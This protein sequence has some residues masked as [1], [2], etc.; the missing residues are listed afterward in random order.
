VKR[1]AATQSPA[2]LYHPHLQAAGVQRLH[3]SPRQTM[4]LAQQLYEGID[5]EGERVGLIT[6]MRTDSTHVAPEAHAEARAYVSERWGGDYLPAKP[7]T[8]TRKVA[9]AQEAH[10]AIRPTSVMRTPEAMRPFL[11]AQQARL[12]ELIWQR[13][14]ASQMAAAVYDT[15]AVDVT[16]GRDFLFAPTARGWPS[17][18]LAAYS[19]DDDEVQAAE[20]EQICRRSRWARWW[21]DCLLPKQHFTEPPPR[22]SESTL[23]KALEENGVGRPSTYATS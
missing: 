20:A 9:L 16:A 2:A 19:E 18:L 15:M 12:Y 7:P 22:Y 23:I 8:Y 17:P 13:F 14:V 1:A 21:T 6:Y 10:E 11:T 5:L 3:Y 4:R